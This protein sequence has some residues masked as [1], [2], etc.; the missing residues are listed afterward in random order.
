[1]SWHCEITSLHPHASSP[2]PFCVILLTLSDDNAGARWSSDKSC[3]QVK[4][5]QVWRRLSNRRDTST[6]QI[7]HTNGIRVWKMRAD[8]HPCD[9]IDPQFVLFCIILVCRV[10]LFKIPNTCSFLCSQADNTP[11][12]QVVF[13]PRTNQIFFSALGDFSSSGNSD[14]CEVDAVRFM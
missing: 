3:A 1:M 9:T 2:T 8:L 10:E 5:G 7:K 4:N 11:F 6:E 12:G 14:V 13:F